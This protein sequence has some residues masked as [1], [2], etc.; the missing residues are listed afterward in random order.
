M[1]GTTTA[2]VANDF[3][4]VGYLASVMVR[5][6]GMGRFKFNT[7]RAFRNNS[8]SPLPSNISNDTQREIEMD[9]KA[10]V[11]DCY[12]RVEELLLSKRAELDKLAAALVERETLYFNDLVRILEPY[13]TSSDIDRELRQ[14]AE[15]KLVG[16][17]P[18]NPAGLLDSLAQMSTNGGGNGKS[19]G[20]PKTS[21]AS[22]AQAEPTDPTKG[23]GEVPQQIISADPLGLNQGNEPDKTDKPEGGQDKPS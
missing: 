9:I 8:D 2:G 12:K 20:G 1:M 5:E 17:N 19:N 15:R 6:C 22:A 3:E 18:I 10:I 21:D 11:D 14:M 7:D 16:V 13:K 4:K 23:L